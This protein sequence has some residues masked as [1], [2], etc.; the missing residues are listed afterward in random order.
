V[1][2]TEGKPLL[3]ADIDSDKIV[4]AILFDRTEV[5]VLSADLKLSNGSISS[6]ASQESQRF[7]TWS[8]TERST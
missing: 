5:Y 7:T 4:P 3:P 6:F 1:N 2:I 8:H